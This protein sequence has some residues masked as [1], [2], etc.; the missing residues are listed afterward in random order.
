MDDVHREDDTMLLASN[1]CSD[2]LE[3]FANSN[4]TALGFEPL[5]S[6]IEGCVVQSKLVGERGERA[7][8]VKAA[9]V[10]ALTGEKMQD[11]IL[12]STKPQPFL[13]GTSVLITFREETC[14]FE[15]CLRAIQQQGMEVGD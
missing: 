2:Q 4:D 15:R 6:P 11:A 14:E 5:E 13:P 8:Q 1:N 10:V 12:R 9:R 3:L 7:L